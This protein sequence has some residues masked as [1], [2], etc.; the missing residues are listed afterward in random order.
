MWWRS[1]AVK[2][3]CAFAQHV[4]PLCQASVM[5]PSGGLRTC[6]A[7]HGS[8]AAEGAALDHN[9]KGGCIAAGG[10]GEGVPGM[11]ESYGGAVKVL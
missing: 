10:A 7:P 6:G 4:A 3:H 8:G 9:V 5:W 2:S 11:L 1:H